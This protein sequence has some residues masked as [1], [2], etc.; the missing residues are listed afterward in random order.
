MLVSHARGGH[1]PS[2]DDSGAALAG[3]GRQ[4]VFQRRIRTA[5]ALVVVVVGFTLAVG[6]TREFLAGNP[7]AIRWA[8]GSVGLAFGVLVSRILRLAI[9]VEAYQLIV[10]NVFRTYR[11]HGSAIDHFELP[12][13]Y[14]RLW[15][16]GLPVLLKSGRTISASAFAVTPVDTDDGLGLR[17]TASL[18]TWLHAGLEAIPS[19]RRLSGGLLWLWRV[20]L[21][22]LA[23]V[24][25]FAVAMLIFGIVDPTSAGTA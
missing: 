8:S 25:L 3:Q 2:G 10:R 1:P 20:W 12:S 5:Q 22:F 13:A 18:Q 14:G 15:K 24:I 17:V 23:L 16:A 7:K 19:E 4:R 9:V 11:I 21:G 6:P